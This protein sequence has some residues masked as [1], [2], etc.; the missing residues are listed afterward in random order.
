MSQRN[1]LLMIP[2]RLRLDNPSM[3][4]RSILGLLARIR[5]VQKREGAVIINRDTNAATLQ[6]F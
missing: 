2:G 6:F 3:N 5:P 4:A 1:R